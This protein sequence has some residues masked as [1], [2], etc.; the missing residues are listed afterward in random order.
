MQIQAP[1][2]GQAAT[3][4]ASQGSHPLQQSQT[5]QQES[6]Q[7][8]SSPIYFHH[9]FP[10]PKVSTDLHF[11]KIP[12]PIYERTIKTRRRNAKLRGVTMLH[13]L[14]RV[15]PR[16]HH[17]TRKLHPEI[18]IHLLAITETGGIT[19]AMAV[20][21]HLRGHLRGNQWDDLA[22]T[23]TVQSKVVMVKGVARLGKRKG[24]PQAHQEMNPKCGC[25]A[26]D[27]K[28]ANLATR[29]DRK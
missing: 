18:E 21:G 5:A 22:A 28:L 15:S 29:L 27:L 26:P 11:H 12:H 14:R 17:N 20:T 23:N 7:A 10:L 3:P 25:V 6:Q 1:P 2:T 4:F 16:H 13:Q 8:Q 24:H 9:W 19:H